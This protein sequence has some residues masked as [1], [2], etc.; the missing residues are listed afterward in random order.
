MRASS[1]SK[2]SN[3]A[4]VGLGTIQE[5]ESALQQGEDFRLVMI[6]LSANLDQLDKVS[7]GL[8]A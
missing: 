7:C 6:S 5:T 1:F 2:C 8:G 3:G 4:G